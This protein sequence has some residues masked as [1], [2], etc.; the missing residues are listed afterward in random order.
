[1]SAPRTITAIV[2]MSG[3]SADLVVGYCQPLSGG[4]FNVKV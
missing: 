3:V 1:V 2:L 4:K